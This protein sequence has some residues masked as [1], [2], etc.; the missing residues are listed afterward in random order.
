M[1]AAEPLSSELDSSLSVSSMDTGVYPG[2]GPSLFCLPV[3]RTNSY[4]L[5]HVG[6]YPWVLGGETTVKIIWIIEWQGQMKPK[7]WLVMATSKF[8]PVQRPLLWRWREL[9]YQ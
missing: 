4:F 5:L 2:N 9:I 3:L 1:P 7:R 6:K 8:I